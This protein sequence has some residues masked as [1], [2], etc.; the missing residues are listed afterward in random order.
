MYNLGLAY[1]KTDA[2]EEAVRAY[3][4]ALIIQEEFPEAHH[5]LAVILIGLGLCQESKRHFDRSHEMGIKT[6]PIVLKQYKAL[7]EAPPE[8]SQESGD[9]DTKKP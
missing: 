3:H 9:Q 8:E 7:C 4:Q 1:T 6:V 2:L 5:N